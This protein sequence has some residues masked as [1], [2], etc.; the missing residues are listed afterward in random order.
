MTRRLML[1]V[2]LAL[3]GGCEQHERNWLFRGE[4]ISIDGW[5]READ[6]TCPGTFEY[7]DAYSAMLAAEFGVEES[8]GVYRWV[9]K[10]HFLAGDLPCP[11]GTACVSEGEAHSPFLPDEHEVVH[12]ANLAVTDCPSVL[13]EGLAVYYGGT[14]GSGS[15]SGGLDLLA[16]R[17]NKPDAQIPFQEYAIAGRFAS[18]LVHEFGLA[19]VLDVCAA[20]GRYAKAAR[21]SSAMENILGA[22]S[23]ELVEQL[24]AEPEA[25][26][27]YPSYQA[28]LYA[29]GDDPRAPDAGIVGLQ[30]GSD[31][32]WRHTF[33]FGCDDPA[34]VGSVDGSAR[35]IQQ[36]ELPEAALYRI[37]LG[38]LFGSEPPLPVTIVLA[39]CGYCGQVAEFSGHD[40]QDFELEPGRY[41][42]EVRAP[43]DFVGDA[44]VE[45][46]RYPS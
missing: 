29:C 22:S 16:A 18:F 9:S 31:F 12:L 1:G 21:L 25:C 10:E 23:S 4:W 34:S 30:P 24:A 14:R 46:W 45:I 42:L 36:I 3:V 27:E 44:D 41:W 15:A 2:V 13:A 40:I 19:A 20:T 33:A 38:H 39:K 37:S 32:A 6:E 17:M 8:L 7:F 5:G 43:F 35:F 26:N 11:S 28:K